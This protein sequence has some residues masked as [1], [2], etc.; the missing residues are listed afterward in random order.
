MYAK[1]GSLLRIR[2]VPPLFITSYDYKY[3]GKEWQDEL[4][5]NMYDFGARNYDPAIGRWMNVDPLAE[6]SRRWSTYT[7]CYNNPMIFVDYDGMFATPPTDFFNL[8]GKHVKHVPDGLT[9][10]K[11]ILSKT[12][13]STKVDEAIDNG[14]VINLPT[15]D[16]ISKMEESYKKTEK[17]SNEHGF[18]VATDGT[19]SSIKEGNPD[20]INLASSYK[21]LKDN[22]KTGSYD[23]HVHPNTEE[24][25]VKNLGHLYHLQ[26]MVIPNHTVNMEKIARVLY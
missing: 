11:I 19:A 7:Y 17:T 20:N 24:N 4:G 25:G 8:D 26:K 15:S 22:G 3:N 12:T 10:K 1:D 16:V 14:E 5:L 18:A 21:E 2:P 13:D 9:D 23:V 6:K